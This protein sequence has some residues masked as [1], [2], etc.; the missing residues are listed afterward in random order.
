MKTFLVHFKNG[1]HVT[2]KSYVLQYNGNGH[3]IGF[4]KDA[5]DRDPDVYVNS[6]EVLY[7]VPAGTSDTEAK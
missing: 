4:G 1:E 2:I 7:I 6:S 3:F 5:K